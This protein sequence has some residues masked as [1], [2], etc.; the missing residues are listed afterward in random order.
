MVQHKL[1]VR[2]NTYEKP[3]VKQGSGLLNVQGIYDGRVGNLWPTGQ[4]EPHL[5]F[6]TVC[7]LKMVLHFYIA[8]KRK[9]IIYDKCSKA[10]H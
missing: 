2:F 3:R 7:E 1:N 5:Y 6:P 10:I 8:G 4:R 9:R